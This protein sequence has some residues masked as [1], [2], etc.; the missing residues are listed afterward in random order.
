[1]GWRARF[2]DLPL[3]S[4]PCLPLALETCS[5]LLRDITG[6]A[7]VLFVRLPHPCHLPRPRC[8]CQCVIGIHV[9]LWDFQAHRYLYKIHAIL[10]CVLLLPKSY[11]VY[12][13]PHN[14]FFLIQQHIFRTFETFLFMCTSVTFCICMYP[15]MKALPRPES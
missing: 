8:H 15:A 6:Q 12:S 3:R 10:V 13:S 14:L 2:Q 1:M 9:F 4:L 5:F 7:E 11:H